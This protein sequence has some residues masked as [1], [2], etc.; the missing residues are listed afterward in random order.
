[1]ASVHVALNKHLLWNSKPSSIQI[2]VAN[3]HYISAS[4]VGDI[5]LMCKCGSL[6]LLRGILYSPT[7]NK[8]IISAPQ[9]PQSKE[10]KTTVLKN[11]V[12]IKYQ[13]NVQEYDRPLSTQCRTTRGICIRKPVSKYN[14]K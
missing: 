14:K 11:S 1:M 3:G 2:R 12:K 8:N 10:Y 9:I 4:L 6:L 7:F 13:G 5:L